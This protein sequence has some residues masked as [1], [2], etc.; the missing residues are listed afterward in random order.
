M[1]IVEFITKAGSICG[2]VTAIGAMVAV[3]LKPVRKFIVN[4]IREIAQSESHDEL[5]KEIREIK[6]S[7]KY[8]EERDEKWH[9]EV[10]RRLTLHS[11]TDIVELRNTINNIYD[12]NYETQTLSMRE[13][14]SLIDLF[15]QYKLL[16]GNHNVEQKYNEMMEWKIRI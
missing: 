2:A 6:A 16:G 10:E 12:K 11:Q 9:K 14:E 8:L 1:E 4:K 13:K 5:I 15:D 7:L 3:C